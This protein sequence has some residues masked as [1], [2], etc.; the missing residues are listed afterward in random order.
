M[1]HCRKNRRF[2]KIGGLKKTRRAGQQPPSFFKSP[3]VPKS[4]RTPSFVGFGVCRFVSDFEPAGASASA[5]APTTES[6]ILLPKFEK[7]FFRIQ[8]IFSHKTNLICKIFFLSSLGLYYPHQTIK[9]PV[10]SISP[11][12]IPLIN[13]PPVTKKPTSI[14]KVGF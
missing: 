14:T 10:K 5:P 9:S 4:P 1:K 2:W 6:K 3:T 7:I 8:N 13:H 12:Y 11:L